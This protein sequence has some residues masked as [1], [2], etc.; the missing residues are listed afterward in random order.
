MHS[1]DGFPWINQSING[2]QG[3]LIMNAFLRD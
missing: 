2:W 3:L 1:I